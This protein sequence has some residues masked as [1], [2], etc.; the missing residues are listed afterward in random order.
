MI[1]EL[2]GHGG[3]G[4]LTIGR[5]LADRMSGRLLDNHTIYNPAF[6][7][8]TFR[9]PEFYET[10]QAVRTIAF[11][12]AAQLPAQVPIVITMAT[13]TA[14][15]WTRDWQVAIRDLADRRSVPLLGVHIHCTLEENARRIA[16]PTRALLRKLTDPASLNDGLD[17]PVLLDHCDRT[18]DLDVTALDPEQ[19]VDQIHAWTGMCPG[20]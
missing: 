17:R 14:L 6:A 10:V 8:T 2:S 3:V 11:D 20:V 12:R 1:I 9:S 7:M 13:G 5:A 16:E 19:A 4:K 18:M 15:W